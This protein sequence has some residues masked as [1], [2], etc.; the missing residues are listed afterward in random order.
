MLRTWIQLVSL[1]LALSTGVLS[2]HGKSMLD[3]PEYQESCSRELSR[4]AR[5]VVQRHI[6]QPAAAASVVL[7]NVC[8]FRPELDCYYEHETN[9]KSETYRGLWQSSYSQKAFKSERYLDLHLQRFWSQKISPNATEC[10]GMW[11]DVLGCTGGNGPQHANLVDENSGHHLEHKCRAVLH[12]CFPPGG[13]AITRRFQNKVF[14]DLCS[15]SSRVERAQTNSNAALDAST[16]L[17]VQSVVWYTFILLLAFATA[18][19][20]LC[21]YLQRADSIVDRDLKKLRK[22]NKFF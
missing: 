20:Y 22:G 8:P 9:G 11:C 18:L 2:Q 16:R 19:F 13:G 3:L 14:E 6:L 5:R 7:S 1:L 10:L 15:F 17:S 4:A 12:Q 21:Y